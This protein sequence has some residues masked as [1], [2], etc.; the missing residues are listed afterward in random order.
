MP[1]PRH[2]VGFAIEALA[3]LTVDR[4]LDRQNLQ[5]VIPRQPRMLHEVH[6]AHAACTQRA[7]DGVPGEDVA[8]T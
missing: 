6:L 3:V 5:G 7:H 8:F 4:E 1:Q 2:Y